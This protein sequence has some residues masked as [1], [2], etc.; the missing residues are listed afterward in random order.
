M[1]PRGRLKMKSLF[2]A[3]SLIAIALLSPAQ[4]D[5]RGGGGHGGGGIAHGGSGGGGGYYYANGSAANPV[6]GPLPSG[7]NGYAYHPVGAGY[8]GRRFWGGGYGYGYN[9]AANANY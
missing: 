9:A 7:S 1:I 8:W 5:A 2:V 6:R 3:G 4:C